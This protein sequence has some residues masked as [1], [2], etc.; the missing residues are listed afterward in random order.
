MWREIP[1]P[2]QS[3]LRHV[4]EVRQC[5]EIPLPK[6]LWSGRFRVLMGARHLIEP[7]I[8]HDRVA[9]RSDTVSP[10]WRVYAGTAR[11]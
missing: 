9:L 3:A 7:W 5:E 8:E 6:W 4:E 11:E 1:R 10:G 2:R